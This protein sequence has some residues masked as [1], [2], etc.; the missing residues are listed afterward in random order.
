MIIIPKAASEEQ[1]LR[2]KVAQ[3]KRELQ[4][5][6]LR[7]QELEAQAGTDP[8]TQIPNRRTFDKTL[9]REWRCQMRSGNCISL[10]IIDIDHFKLYNDTHGH[11]KGDRLLKKLAKAWASVPE[12]ACDLVARYGGEEFAVILPN[13]GAMG[14]RKVAAD[15]LAVT[16]CFGATCS[17]GVATCTPTQN[18]E[19][20]SLI[21]LADTRLYSAKH[22]GRDRICFN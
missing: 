12:R 11:P 13:T 17:I 22:Q 3:L 8:L 21:A 10:L 4:L 14:A 7:N 16:R 15:I 5:L 18:I 2:I 9:D 20:E 19:P 6:S 1:R